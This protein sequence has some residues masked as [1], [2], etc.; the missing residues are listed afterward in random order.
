MFESK[1]IENTLWSNTFNIWNIAKQRR[2]CAID[3]IKL[4]NKA[5]AF[6]V[7]AIKAFVGEFDRFK[8]HNKPCLSNGRIFSLH[9]NEQKCLGLKEKWPPVDCNESLIISIKLLLELRK[10]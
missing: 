9:L 10:E 8:T 3:I 6:Y 5:G 1:L 2:Q 4:Q 7:S